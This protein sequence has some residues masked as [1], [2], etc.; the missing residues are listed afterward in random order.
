M[1]I[2]DLT[3]GRTSYEIRFTYSVLFECA[4]GIAIA[5]YPQ[6]HA[7]L[8]KPEAYWK[9]TTSQLS[10]QLQTEL[11]YCERNNTWKTLLQLLHQQDFVDIHTFIGYLETLSQEELRYLSLPFLGGSSQED[12]RKSAHGDALA[13]EALVATCQ[14]HQFFPAY[15][16]FVAGVDGEELRRHLIVLIQLWHDQY[17][18]VHAPDTMSI[19]T[20]D[21]KQKQ[22][23][24]PNLAP[25]DFV[26]W[27]TGGVSYPPEPTVTSVLLVPH[28]AYRPWTIQADM[29]G[30]KILYY[31]VADQ[32]LD[33]EEDQYR[34]PLALVQRYKALG[35]ETRL[36]ILKLLY[37]QN[38]SLHELTDILEIAK[39][40]V[41]H[42]LALLKSAYLVET[43]D[44]LYGLNHSLLSLA[45]AELLQY[46]KRGTTDETL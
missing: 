46:L 45:D 28:Y 2:L 41:H 36:R 42:H 15:I 32:S 35:D 31:P 16:R 10:K 43:K 27:A 21:I 37:K 26:R 30:T 18:L 25:E 23:M 3:Y 14:L 33:W 38:R 29:E 17:L 19:L 7:T 22:A 13:T 12:R 39:S 34:P 5:T 44:H 24:L 9:E 4:L 6:M 20:R 40:T 8:E 11:E 1:N